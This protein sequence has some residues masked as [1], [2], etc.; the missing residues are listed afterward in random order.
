MSSVL[1]SIAAAGVVPVVAVDV[2]EHALPLAD[3]LLEGGLPVVEV[4]FRTRAAADVIR[5]LSKERPQLIVGAGTV[6][7]PETVQTAVA[8]GARFGV[9]PGLNP[10]VVRAASET[11]FPFIP[12]VATP[13]EIEQGL[14]LGCSILKFFPAESIGGVKLLKAFAGPYKHTGVRFMPTGGVTAE[15]LS[16]YLRLPIVAAAGGTWIA[17]TADMAE[18]KWGDILQRCKEATGLVQSIRGFSR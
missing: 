3:A 12:G 2:V 17:K 10:R 11:G 4:T 5:L 14:E 6:L 7:S 16:D 13:S 15:N 8:C 1:E 9:A 18:G